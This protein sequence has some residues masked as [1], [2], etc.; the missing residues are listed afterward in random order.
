MSAGA[1]LQA[2]VV[3]HL[4]EVGPEGLMVFDAPP[5]RGGVPYAVV[6]EAVLGA[7]DAAGVAGRV[8]TIAVTCIDDGE[9][10]VRLRALVGAV[11][12]AV[13]GLTGDPGQGWRIAGLRL[14]RSRIVAAKGDRWVAT[15]EFAVRL[16]RIDS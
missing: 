12:E 2:A 16:F 4:R 10:P 5:V 1:V 14:A 6:G 3:A 11:E 13:A 15:S 9:R 7:A 8:G